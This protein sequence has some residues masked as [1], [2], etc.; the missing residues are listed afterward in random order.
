MSEYTFENVII[1][2]A[3][4]GIEK[5]IGKEVYFGNTIVGCLC[6]ANMNVRSNL[7]I[8]SEI[9]ARFNYPFRIDRPYDDGYFYED[10]DFLCFIPKKED[11][12]LKYTPFKTCSQFLS[13]YNLHRGEDPESVTGYQLANLGGIWLKSSKN[14][15][16][17]MVTEICDN[18]A[19]IR[20]ACEV[21]PW[22]EI[23]KDFVFLDNTPCGEL[24]GTA[25]HNVEES[26]AK[27]AKTY[28]SSESV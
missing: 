12:E 28:V 11:P 21:T 26:G 2:P 18:G 10:Y 13:A 19:V 1:N 23:Y 16:Y 4:E 3:T 24:K 8:L 14:D 27:S 22:S 25:I 9:H 6:N 5:Y 15:F 7:G 20:Q 17:A